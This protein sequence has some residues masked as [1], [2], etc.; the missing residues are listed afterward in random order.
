MKK[1]YTALAVIGFAAVST[2]YFLGINTPSSTKLIQDPNDLDIAFIKFISK[3]DRHYVTKEE[4]LQRME[5]FKENLDKVL[6]HNS[7][8]GVSYRLGINK[9]SDW[10]E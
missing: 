5:I 3:Y 7:K 4:F 1:G 2:V 10:T 8:N 6:A 9:F